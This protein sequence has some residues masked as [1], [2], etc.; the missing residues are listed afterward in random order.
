MIK[1]NVYVHT[2]DGFAS[3]E[4]VCCGHIVSGGHRLSPIASEDA[5]PWLLVPGPGLTFTYFYSLLF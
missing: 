3:N 2:R 5:V 1:I 4:L